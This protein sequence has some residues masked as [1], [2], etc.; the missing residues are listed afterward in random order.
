MNPEVIKAFGD[1]ACHVLLQEVGGPVDLKEP[2]VRGGPIVLDEVAVAIAMAQRIE[3]AMFLSLSASTSL[4]YLSHV[5]GLQVT[6]LDAIAQSGIGEL[7]NMI[8]GVATSRLAQAGYEITIFPPNVF[9]GAG[10]MSMRG[11][12]RLVLPIAIPFGTIEIHLAARVRP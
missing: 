3:G 12:P 5:L 9:V 4:Q 2:K 6:E 10:T 8:A 11:F 1:A 7:A